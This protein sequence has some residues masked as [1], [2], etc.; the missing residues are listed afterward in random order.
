LLKMRPGEMKIS[1]HQVSLRGALAVARRS[2]SKL[3]EIPRSR[4][5]QAPQSRRLMLGLPRF[6]RNDLEFQ[7]CIPIFDMGGQA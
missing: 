2:R 6:A 4:S 3:D 5:E 1:I 7:V